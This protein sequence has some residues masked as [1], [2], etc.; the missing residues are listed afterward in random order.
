[1]TK[2]EIKTLNEIKSNENIVVVQ[3]D[4]GGKIVILDKDEYIKKIEEKLLDENIYEQITKDPTEHIKEKIK[5]E[6]DKLLALNKINQA[7]HFEL[8][9]IDDLP[10][11]RGQ[12]KLHK[13]NNPMRIVTCSKDTITSPVSRFVFKMIK[14]LRS[15]IDGVVCNTMKFVEEISDLPIKKEEHLASLDIQDLFTNIPVTR[16]VDIVVQKLVESNKLIN[17]DLTK[18]DIKRLL[19]VSLNNSYFQFNGKFYRQKKGLPMG[20]SLSPLLADLYMD[21]YLKEH[22]KEVNIPNKIWRYVD[23]ILILTEKNEQQLNN[24]VEKLNK[25]RG[26]IR[27]TY[28]FEQ[29]DKISFLDTTLSRRNEGDQMKIKVRWFRKTT[30]ADRLLNYKSSHSKSIKN[31]IVKN[32]ATRILKTT[33]EAGEQKEDLQ[34]LKQMLLNSNY[35]LKE[36]DKLIK[37]SCESN[38]RHRTSN[39][40]DEETKYSVSLPYVPGMEVLKRKLEKLK[41]KLYFSYPNK[42]Q[43]HFNR[44]L[45]EP[46]KSVIY[47]IQC[48]CD[49][50]QIYN[51]E[52]KVGIDNRMKQHFRLINNDEE[53]SE[54]VQHQQQNRYQCLFDTDNAF[55]VEQEKNWRKRRLKEAIYSK[56]NKSVNEHDD[57]SSD[58]NPIL[59]KAEQ[60]IKRK[61]QSSRETFEKYKR[62]KT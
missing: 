10:R 34:K 40:K 31:N 15:T 7:K 25:I 26:S 1:M 44:T 55:I 20:N 21:N 8:T 33:K 41:I 58:W 4:K 46:S 11:I 6:A 54:M 5:T 35:P 32:M 18:T 43:S 47:Q 23:D 42:I 37:Q 17:S 3:A 51:G 12:P 62:T 24:Y 30:A 14:D 45:K 9:G 28:E 60:E 19:L 39:K 2:E 49:P 53:K 48:S 52:T 56:V 27:F 59:Y 22:L 61:I 16:A 38:N 57:I 36:I 29:N 13:V 50:P